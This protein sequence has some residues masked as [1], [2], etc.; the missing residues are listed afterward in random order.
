MNINRYKKRKW[1]QMKISLA[2]TRTQ[3]KVFLSFKQGV[4]YTLSG[5]HLELVD[6]FP[7]LCNNISSTERDVNITLIQTKSMEKMSHGYYSRLL[8]TVLNKPMKQH[9]TK[10]NRY[11]HLTSISQTIQIRGI[12]YARH[13]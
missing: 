8:G 9:L 10:Q 5:K 1:F 2:S 7:Y 4:I 12:R 3:L 13:C 6:Q 11:G